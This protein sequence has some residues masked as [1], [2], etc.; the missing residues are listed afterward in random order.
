MTRL[1]IFLALIQL[2]NAFISPTIPNFLPY[3]PR[4]L[5]NWMGS[6]PET[7]IPDTN[8]Q[9][10][11]YSE[12]PLDEIWEL[13]ILPPSV[14]SNLLTSVRTE[15]PKAKEIRE[16]SYPVMM[17][18]NLDTMTRLA[19]FLALIECTNAFISP[20]IPNFL[21]YLPRSLG[22]WMGSEPEA[23]IPDTNQQDIDYY[24]DQRENVPDDIWDLT[25]LPPSVWS[26]LWSN[27]LR[28]G[29]TEAPKTKEIREES[30]PIMMA[31]L[32]T[33]K[34]GSG[35]THLPF[36]KRLVLC[37]VSLQENSNK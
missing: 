21:P 17:S 3:L 33:R 27:H 19:I 16:D 20:T 34:Y 30:Y 13:S 15:A 10:I 2:T 1:A 9:D 18:R 5:G 8:Q 32:Q 6:E 35:R 28:F 4:S 31:G 12:N 7:R 11:D 36:G 25:I 29:R 23:R 22:N 14:W 37:S 26:N 24:E